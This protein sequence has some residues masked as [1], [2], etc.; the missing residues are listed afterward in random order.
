MSTFK[1]TTTKYKCKLYP[2]DGRYPYDHSRS[3]TYYVEA[4]DYWEAKR[5]L[6][7]MFGPGRWDNL[8]NA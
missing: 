2:V 5:T 1:N 8:T 3:V 4:V 6:N 7:S